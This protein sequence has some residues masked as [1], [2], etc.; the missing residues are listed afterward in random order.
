MGTIF[1]EPRPELRVDWH[2]NFLP[3]AGGSPRQ[4]EASWKNPGVEASTGTSLAIPL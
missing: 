4:D 3:T 2:G 1:L